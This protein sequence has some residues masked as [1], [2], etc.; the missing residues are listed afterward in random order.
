MRCEMFVSAMRDVPLVACAEESLLAANMWPV[1]Q[2]GMQH[3]R[4][5][6]SVSVSAS[7]SVLTAWR[8]LGER[9]GHHRVIACSERTSIKHVGMHVWR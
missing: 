9:K 8:A 3:V 7:L 6:R 2:Q 4:L 1:V 5:P